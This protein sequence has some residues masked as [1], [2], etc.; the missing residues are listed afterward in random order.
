[1]EP[2]WRKFDEPM[3]FRPSEV[4]S[5]VVRTGPCPGPCLLALV[6]VFVILSGA[7][8]QKTPERAIDRPLVEKQPEL[9]LPAAERVEPGA[10][11]L[12]PTSLVCAEVYGSKLH[13]LFSPQSKLELIHDSDV[14]VIWQ[15]CASTGSVRSD[16]T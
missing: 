12:V 16:C 13:K 6:T 4:C 14:I 8:C 9:P 3:K 5:S 2:D 11:A 10:P 7:G 1:M 15:V